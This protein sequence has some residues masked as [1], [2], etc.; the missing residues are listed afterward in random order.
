MARERRVNAAHCG[1]HPSYDF[2]MDVFIVQFIL[3]P[4]K[5]TVFAV[6]LTKSEQHV[7]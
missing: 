6:H 4:G 2:V 1:L 7:E 3:I 5:F